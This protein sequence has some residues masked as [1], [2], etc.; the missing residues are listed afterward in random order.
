MTPMADCVDAGTGKRTPWHPGETLMDACRRLG[1]DADAP[2]ACKGLCGKC[3]VRVVSG[4]PPPSGACERFLGPDKL[5]AGWRLACQVRQAGTG[6]IAVDGASLALSG[7]G[8]AIMTALSG[9]EGRPDD[10]PD[11]LELRLPPPSLEDQRPDFER[12]SEA[13]GRTGAGLEAG[14]E[15]I[16]PLAVLRGLP[17][18]L[19]QNSWHVGAVWQGPRLLRVDPWRSGGRSAGLAVD[20]GTT[21]VAGALVDLRTGENLAVAACAN[22]QSAMGD[23]VISRIE[24][25][26]AGDEGRRGLA[27]RA[28]GA[29]DGLLEETCRQAGLGPDSVHRIAVAGNTTMQHLLLGLDASAIAAAPFVATGRRGMELPAGEAGLRACGPGVPLLLLPCVSAYVGGD[30]VAGLLAEG[31]HGRA[32]RGLFLDVGTNGEMALA[33]DGRTW[34]CSTAAGP[35]FEGARIRCGTR[36]SSGAIPAVSWEGGALRVATIH[37]APPAGLCGTG[38]LDAVATLLDLGVVDETGRLLDGGEYAESFPGAAPDILGRLV[39]RDGGPAFV[40]ARGEP[41][42]GG[43]AAGEGREVYLTQRDIREFQLAKGAI[44]A[45]AQ[46]MLQEAGIAWDGLDTVWLAGGFGNWLRPASALRVGL[47]G[48]SLPVGRIAF[49]GNAALAG[50]RLYL[51]SRAERR[52]AERLRREVVYRELSGRP[53]FQQAFALEMMFPEKV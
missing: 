6:D 13:S 39:E 8:M 15:A 37:R 52:E 21:T 42:A 17:P 27:E 7:R 51:I 29:I 41:E 34:A 38:L 53:D 20:L 30:I 43:A 46:V 31:V 16:A 3:G 1:L 12:L 32:G 11:W 44:A 2:C 5:A 19:R 40:L 47:L 28:A 48:P 25:A 9:R 24:R 23:D 33:A 18:V 22:P 49:V 26:A 14:A 36:A 4:A 50:A 35:A 45:G 10:A